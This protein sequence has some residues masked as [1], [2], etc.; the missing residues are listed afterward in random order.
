MHLVGGLGLAQLEVQAVHGLERIRLLIDKHKEPLV[1]PRRQD[2][3]GAA[4]DLPLAYLAC[5]GL[6]RGIEGRIGSEKRWQQP[7]KLFVCQ[8]G[9][10]EKLSR[11]GL[12]GSVG[13]HAVIIYYS[14]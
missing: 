11:S 4:T 10:S 5:D 1:F 14:R 9:C 12:Q 7:H 8:S 13:S 3:F 6:I 2:A